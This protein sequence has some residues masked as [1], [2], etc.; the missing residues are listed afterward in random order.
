MLLCLIGILFLDH[1][2]YGLHEE[3]NIHQHW[4]VRGSMDMG[5][6]WVGFPTS[7][8]QETSMAVLN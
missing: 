6:P 1:H 2:H 3:A 7:L 4:K 8:P 5:L